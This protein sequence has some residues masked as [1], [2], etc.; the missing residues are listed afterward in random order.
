MVNSE[1]LKLKSDVRDFGKELVATL[2][3]GY[4]FEIVNLSR[5][6]V[7]AEFAGGAKNYRP[8]ILGI[9]A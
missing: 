4:D 9:R 7:H 2:L 5:T 8:G 6:L 3:S 1:T